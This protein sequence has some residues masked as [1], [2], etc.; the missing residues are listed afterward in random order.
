MWLIFARIIIRKRFFILGVVFAL[1]GMFGYYI[2]KIELNR[3]LADMLPPDHDG[4]KVY[5][6]MRK[7]FGEDGMVMVVAVKDKKLYQYDHFKAWHE[8]GKDMRKIEGVDSVFSEAH[9]YTLRKDTAEK[10][11]LLKPTMIGFPKDQAGVDS[12]RQ[13][14]RSL[15]FYENIL[16]NPKTGTSLMLVFIDPPYFNS[17]KRG[18][19]V[20]NIRAATEKYQKLLGTMYYSGL[21]VVRDTLFRSLKN[22]LSLFVFL[23]IVASAI[24]LYIF[25]RSFRA[26]FICMVV[27]IIGLVWS[28]GTMGL[29]HYK[30]TSLMSLIPPL[31]III[32]IPNCIYLINKYHQEY[33]KARSKMK[34]LTQ[35]IHKLG[36]ATFITNANTALGF[37]TFCFTGN[38]KLIQFGIVSSVNVMAMFFISLT[39]IPIIFTFM[40][41]PSVKHTKHL[42]KKWSAGIINFLVNLI[43]FRRPITYIITILVTIWGAY[44]IFMIRTTGNIVSDLPS[45]SKVVSDLEFLEK[46]FGGVMPMEVVINTK[47]KGQILKDKTLERIDSAQRYL[48]T[49]PIYTKSLSIVDAA[50][51]INQAF[52]GGFKEDY[53]FISKSDKLYIAR[54]LKNSLRGTKKDQFKSFIDSSETITRITASMAD[55]GTL[56]IRDAQ[57]KLVPKLDSIMNPSKAR[58]L[59]YL[60][61]IKNKKWQGTERDEKL[62]GLY[63]DD[64]RLYNKLREIVADGDS[65]LY[66]ELY[67]NYELMSKQHVH[68]DFPKNLE[69]AIHAVNFDIAITGNSTIFALGTNYMINDMIE[70]LVMAILVISGLMFFLFTSARMIIIS[71]VPNI[72]PQI[73]IAGIMGWFNIP[74]KPSTI[75]VFSLAYGISVDNSIHYLAKYRQEL[76][77]QHFNIRNCVAVALR[78]T[79]L[80]QVYTSIVLLLG[81]SMF[82]FSEFGATIALGLLVSLSLFIAMFCNLIIL[83]ALLMTLDR[84]IA[85]KAYEEPFLSIYDEEE[86]I[87]LN[88][89]EI[90]FKEDAPNE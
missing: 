45:H 24:I 43:T 59:Y 85:I 35:V 71:L 38:H 80:S 23:S 66:E 46:E 62:F 11:F 30:V 88:Q 81:F 86:D 9:M 57:E 19:L 70:S 26:L 39:I 21:P 73:L 52:R 65:A 51:F 14:N 47:E 25:F 63:D 31:M 83:P 68:P 74:I 49:Y 67:D 60:K 84:S 28:F 82:C 5:A 13:V 16:Y 1:T 72:I 29:L 48:A 78:E 2:T 12:I 10:K 18:D 64:F 36:V 79:F 20:P 55:V 89:L 33:V 44:G 76:R 34:A 4:M 61:Q 53:D 32:G 22:E 77:A 42:D 3:E 90:D 17:P 6:K 40:P 58:Q 50:K 41:D 37:L 8:L 56:E 75:L 15:P 7:L 69:K 87:D 27:I 54:Y